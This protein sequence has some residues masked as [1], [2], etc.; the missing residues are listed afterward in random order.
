MTRNRQ[1]IGHTAVVGFLPKEMLQPLHHSHR[2]NR[3]CLNLALFYLRH[4]FGFNTFSV[5]MLRPTTCW[6]QAAPA[7][8]ACGTSET[9]RRAAATS[10]HR[11]GAE[12]VGRRQPA[13]ARIVELVYCVG[14]VCIRD[15][16]KMPEKTATSEF[17]PKRASSNE[18]FCCRPSAQRVPPPKSGARN[19]ND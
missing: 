17:D 15:E 12:V 2:V 9:C 18:R 5:D 13:H 8:S 16:T 1:S 19:S 3:N 4:A 14:R 10:V 6:S 11:G 7:M